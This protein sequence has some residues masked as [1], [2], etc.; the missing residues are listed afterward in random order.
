MGLLQ[1][2]VIPGERQLDQRPDQIFASVISS[3]RLLRSDHGS[4]ESFGGIRR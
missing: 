1:E 2:A 3:K 4:T